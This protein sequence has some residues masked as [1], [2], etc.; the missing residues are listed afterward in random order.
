MTVVCTGFAV[1][2]GFPFQIPIEMPERLL[3]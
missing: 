2:S 1:R 3:H